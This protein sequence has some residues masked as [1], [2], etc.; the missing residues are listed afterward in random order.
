[1]MR[2]NT[3]AMLSLVATAG[4]LVGCDNAAARPAGASAGPAGSSS[5]AAPLLQPDAVP[6]KVVVYYFHGERRCRTCM[7]IQA[8]IVRT[9]R[10]RFAEDTASGA[11][12]FQ[13]INYEA[14]GNEHFVKDFDLSFST[15]VVVARKGQATVKWKNTEVWDYAHDQAALADY[16]EREIRNYLAMVKKS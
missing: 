15:M 13:E 2:A 8:T 9:I 14:P 5:T 3:L 11:L 7:G 6:D 10:E 12:V 4:V 16:A 1:M